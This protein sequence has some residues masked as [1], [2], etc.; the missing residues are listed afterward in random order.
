MFGC[1]RRRV[2]QVAI[3]MFRHKCQPIQVVRLDRILL[4]KYKRDTSHYSRAWASTAGEGVIGTAS[5]FLLDKDGGM[6][7]WYLF[8]IMLRH[9]MAYLNHHS[10]AEG[11]VSVNWP[12]CRQQIL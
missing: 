12:G 1:A 7:A 6:C 3:R 5:A 10:M 4:R 11:R 9:P 8:R 2:F